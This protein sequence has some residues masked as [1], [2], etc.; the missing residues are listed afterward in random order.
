M[1]NIKKKNGTNELIYKTE[2]EVTNLWLPG[3]KQGRRDKLEAW[4]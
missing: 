3:S 2:I 4:G 1:W